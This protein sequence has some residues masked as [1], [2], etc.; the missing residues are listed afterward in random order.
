MIPNPP[1]WIRSMITTWPKVLQYVAVSTTM[2]P[3]TQTAEVDVNAA[4]RK[5]AP[6]SS[7]VAT[8]SIRSAE[9]TRIATAKATP[10]SRAG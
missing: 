4:V 9:P 7:V 2:R 1:I 8:G 6:P 10:I 5:D 3:V